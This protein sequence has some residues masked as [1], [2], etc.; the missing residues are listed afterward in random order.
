MDRLRNGLLRAHVGCWLDC[1]TIAWLAFC[2]SHRFGI[3]TDRCRSSFTISL[4]SHYRSAH[5]E[6][7][8][9][10]HNY[11]RFFILSCDVHQILHT[12]QFVW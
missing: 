9:I 6:I 4:V 1:Y 3:S 11:N 8:A 7:Y 5:R 2:V 10:K 12:I